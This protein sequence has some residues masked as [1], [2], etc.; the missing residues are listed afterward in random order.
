MTNTPA[1]AAQPTNAQLVQ[2]AIQIRDHIKAED[3]AHSLRMKPWKDGL[4]AIEG[5]L[6]VKLTAEN[7]Q[8]IKTEFGT[9]FFKTSMSLK[10]SDRNALFT[11][12]AMRVYDAGKV[13]DLQAALNAL[14]I[15]SSNLAK[16]EVKAYMAKNNDRCPPGVE[17][18]YFK[19][20]QIR[21]A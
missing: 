21:R 13:G 14:Q 5:I 2:R 16:D 6:N 12:I 15:V 7:E 9:A 10:V 3:E 20:V 8:N 18:T 11:D 4:V 17:A 1:E 19:E